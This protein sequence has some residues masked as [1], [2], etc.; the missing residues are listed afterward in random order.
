MHQKLLQFFLIIQLHSNFY[1]SDKIQ[2][3][4]FP[5]MHHFIQSKNYDL[6]LR[7]LEKLIIQKKEAPSPEP[8]RKSLDSCALRMMATQSTTR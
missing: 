3:I 5:S 2:G 4:A 8:I 1:A 6:N 7:L